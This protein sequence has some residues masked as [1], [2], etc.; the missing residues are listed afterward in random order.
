MCA[1]LVRSGSTFSFCSQLTRGRFCT[2]HL[3]P[4]RVTTTKAHAAVLDGGVLI[5]YYYYYY[6]Y[7]HLAGTRDGSLLSFL[8]FSS[9]SSDS[10]LY[11]AH[12]LS[13][14]LHSLGASLALGWLQLQQKEVRK[15]GRRRRRSIDR[16]RVQP[17]RQHTHAICAGLLP[18]FFG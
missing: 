1:K 4:D 15:K 5:T 17:T 7:I 10:S 11:C 13:L 8:S 6:Y 12:C 3:T 9:L 2:R 16:L 14:K 18:V